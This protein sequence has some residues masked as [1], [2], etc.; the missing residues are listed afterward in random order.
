MDVLF[1]TTQ[2]QQQQQ[3]SGGL[4]GNMGQSNT[5][6]GQQPAQT[7]TTGGLFGSSTGVSLAEYD[8]GRSETCIK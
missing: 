6:F 3:Q 5:S 4:F 2:Q 7:G 1:Q 8:L